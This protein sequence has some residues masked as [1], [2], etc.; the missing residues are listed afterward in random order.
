MKKFILKNSAGDAVANGGNAF[1]SRME[2]A[3]IF[4]ERDNME[5]K[6]RWFSM[7]MRRAVRSVEAGA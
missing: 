5:I 2:D 4:D 1:T 3:L 7:H 6:V